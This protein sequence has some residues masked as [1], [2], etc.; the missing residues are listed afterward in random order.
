MN[1]YLYNHL[2]NPLL[3]SAFTLYITLYTNK[4]GHTD[5]QTHV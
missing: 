5:R 2:N 1:L 4:Q 3:F